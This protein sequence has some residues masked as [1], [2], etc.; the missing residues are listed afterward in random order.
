MSTHFRT[1]IPLPSTTENTT[2]PLGSDNR[3]F[4]FGGGGEGVRCHCNR[5]G[6]VIKDTKNFLSP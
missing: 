2:S 1:F 5:H 4:F 3:S 6:Q